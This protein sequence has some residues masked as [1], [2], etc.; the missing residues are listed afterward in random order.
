[1]PL[2]K[3][4]HCPSAQSDI[5]LFYETF[6]SPNGEPLLLIMGLGTQMIAW[7]TDLCEALVERGF[8]VIRYDNRDVG[9][10]SHLDHL[11]QPNIVWNY[12]TSF[13]TLPSTPYTLEDMAQDGI[14]LLD[15][16]NVKAAHVCGASMGGMIAQ[17]MCLDYPERVLS[18]TCIMSTTGDPHL[19]E[20]SIS[21]K[22]MMIKKFP[23]AEEDQV[24]HRLWMLESL[25]SPIHWDKAYM[26]SYIREGIQR[27]KY[28]AG[29]PRQLAAIMAAEGRGERLKLVQKPLLVIHGR[30]D[31]LVPCAH[32]EAIASA[33][34]GAEL[35][36]F[37]H[38]GHTMPS[39]YN[40]DLAEAIKRNAERTGKD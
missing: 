25:S 33:V 39:A 28:R 36:L 38:M 14:A 31:K 21:M 10:S 5:E 4:R 9:L 32:G 22:L 34:P 37:D 15:H 16:L 11:G 26:E 35:L 23:T 1:M 29:V 3:V 18:L 12:I 7:H 40:V 2:A 20:A 19:P 8:Y 24:K 27:S 13:F 17:L 30:D 6:G